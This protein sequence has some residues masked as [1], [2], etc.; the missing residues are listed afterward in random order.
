MLKY[1]ARVLGEEAISNP[2][3]YKRKID[4][5]A[6][7]EPQDYTALYEEAAK[8]LEGTDY[9]K[10][11]GLSLKT[12]QRFGLGYIEKWRHPKAPE[13][14][15]YSPRLIIPISKGGYLARDVRVEMPEAEKKYTKAKVGKVQLFNLE[16]LKQRIVYVV[17]G[18]LDAMSM[19]E[20]GVEAVALGS[21]AYKGKLIEAIKSMEEKPEMIVLALDNDEAGRN[22][23]EN[24]QNALQRIGVSSIGVNLYGKS[25]DA[26]EAL[27]A[28]RDELAKK[29]AEVTN[30][31]QKKM[32]KKMRRRT[33][34]TRPKGFVSLKIS[35]K[36]LRDNFNRKMR[37]FPS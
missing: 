32:D 37:S 18:E 29:V 8:H 9:W 16:A 17:E 20:I 14:V 7:E 21:V 4:K 35:S 33:K 2:S 23:S 3:S 19:Y 22:A 6:E 10:E 31:V 12:C 27:R 36:P 15:P 1:G 25:K 13:V 24:V 26:N 28:S 34:I 11:R 5:S 30:R